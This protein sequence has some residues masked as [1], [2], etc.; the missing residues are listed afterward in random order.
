MKKY[1]FAVLTTILLLGCDKV[2][3]IFH[4]SPSTTSA[5]AL[6]F[7]GIDD[8]VNTGDWFRYQVFTIQFW[9]KA[10]ATQNTWAN[11]IDNEHATYISWTIQ[12][13]T[14]STNEYYYGGGTIVVFTLKPGVWQQ[15]TIVKGTDSAAA[16]VNGQLV[17][18]QAVYLHIDYPYNHVLRLGQWAGGARAWNGQLDEVRLWSKALSPQE[19]LNNMNCQLTG[20]ENG[21]VAYYRFNQGTINA[22][23]SGV[24]TLSDLSGHGH[25]GALENF[26]LSGS[27]S[28]WVEG[29][30]SGTCY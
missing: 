14:D 26:S 19:I 2:D 10:G 25:N 9:A 30:V 29:K 11:I 20:S 3:E 1:V 16:Y 24:K 27:R 21:L 17:D 12:Q 23:N 7:D 6:D 8:D 4:H 22:N 5:G 18:K 28:N 15:V 13:R